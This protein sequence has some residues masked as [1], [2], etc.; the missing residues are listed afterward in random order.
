MPRATGRHNETRDRIAR[1]YFDLSPLSCRFCEQ[2]TPLPTELTDQ[3]VT[4]YSQRPFRADVAALGS[5]GQIVAVIEVVDTNLPKERNLVA[6]AE[7][8]LAFYVEPDALDSGFTGYCSPFCWTNRGQ[9]HSSAWTAP[10]CSCCERPFFT[11]EFT[12]E[13]VDWEDPYHPVCIECAA[14][15]TGGQWRSPGKLALGDPA[16]RIPGLD[17]DVL[18]LF[19]S[20]C[21]ADFWAMA[22]TNR[23][24]KP[25]EP[26][27]EVDTEIVTAV[28]L[29]EV[30]AAFDDGKWDNGERM[31]QPIGAP[32]WD[33]PPGPA[34]YAWNRRNCVQTA[35]AWRRLR[36]HRLSCLPPLIQSGIRSRPPLADVVTDV[37]QVVLIHRGFPDGRFTACGIDR[38]KSDEPIEATMKGEVTCR[39]CK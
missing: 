2:S 1:E 20:F 31:L 19:L 21:D 38:E 12:Y 35:L 17:A 11:L 26:P 18:D 7:L 3:V 37:A 36:E 14:K 39:D 5:S 33:R 30:E 6:Q 8:P 32:A 29:N 15:A 23:T 22:W 24:V 4:E 13:L 16:D 25:V 28:R 34:L 10:I 9:K 27:P